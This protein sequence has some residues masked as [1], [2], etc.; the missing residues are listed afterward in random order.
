MSTSFTHEAQ[1]PN[2]Y[3]R[4]MANLIPE[5][6]MDRNG[7][8]VTRHVKAS[9]T[10]KPSM[11]QVPA[12]SAGDMWKMRSSLANALGISV[13]GLDERLRQ[14]ERLKSLIGLA[15]R[16]DLAITK[17][18][19]LIEYLTEMPSD[20]DF[21]DCVGLLDRHF[22]AACAALDSSSKNKASYVNGIVTGVNVL[23][24]DMTHEQE[25]LIIEVG[26]RIWGSELTTNHGYP[27]LNAVFPKRS[28]EDDQRCVGSTVM[29]ED[30][31]SYLLRHPEKADAVVKVISE[32]GI[33]DPQL[34]D[35]LIEE[36]SSAAVPLTEGVL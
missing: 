28:E 22:D 29:R 30:L 16:H 32:R 17:N 8:V 20:E 7:K 10:L 3:L 4:C 6:R 18:N 19:A 14:P 33:S 13:L 23:D 25:R 27:A 12:V 21:M 24:L 26:C 15:T 34:L 2:R 36:F 1:L 31:A 5:R 11:S 9:S 35:G